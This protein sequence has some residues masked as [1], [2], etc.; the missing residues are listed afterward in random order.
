MLPTTT[1]Y[2]PLKNPFPLEPDVYSLPWTCIRPSMYCC[3]T[4]S[5]AG[6]LGCARIL[7]LLETN[8]IYIAIITLN[9][10]KSLKKF[11]K[12]NMNEGSFIIN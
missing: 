1:S 9:L 4:S 7:E 2:L 5:S 11:E 10:F 3:E 6:T 8:T 12:N